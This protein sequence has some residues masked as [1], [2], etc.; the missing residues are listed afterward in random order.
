LRI[1]LVFPFLPYPPDDGGKIGFFNPIKYLARKHEVSV[2]CLTDSSDKESS[3]EELRRNCY[4]LR[5]CQRPAWRDPY[6]LLKGMVLRPPGSAAKYWHAAAGELIRET[7]V[8]RPPDIVEFHHLN[9][10]IYRSFAGAL[11]TVLREH[12][13]E[14]KVWERHGEN[15]T[16]WVERSYARVTAPRVRRYEAEIALHFDRCL[17]VSD[18]DAAH[19]RGISPEARVEVI[20]SGVDTEYFYPFPHAEE[21]PFSMTLTGSF[22][23]KPK[24]QSL[25]ALL[26]QVFPRIKARVPEAKLYVVGKGIPEW[27]RRVAHETPGVRIEGAVPDVRPYIAKS[28][29]LINYLESGGGIALKVLEAMAMRKP[30]LSNSLG[31]EGIPMR[32]G[33][34][35]FVADG[36][37][38]FAAAASSLIGDPALRSSLAEAGYRRVLESYSWDVIAVRLQD[39]YLR[40]IDE[41]RRFDRIP[42]GVRAQYAC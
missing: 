21:E 5:T 11:P 3:I 27:L 40:M 16:S 41:R 24:Q 26:T 4:E 36:S 8:A 37:A 29:L 19:L 17:V 18:A 38:E 10:A 35:F 23:W 39:C 42:D 22:E 33:R 20:P 31:C 15:A 14:F 2:V 1:L 6:R 30:V 25:N 32:H 28:A 9:T 34:D 13:V 7:I 12:N